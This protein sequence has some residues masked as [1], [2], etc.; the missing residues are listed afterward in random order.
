[1]EGVHPNETDKEVLFPVMLL[2]QSK[3][4]QRETYSFMTRLSVMVEE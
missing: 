1:M 4:I 3:E 2:T